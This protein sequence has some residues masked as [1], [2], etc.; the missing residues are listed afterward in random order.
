MVGPPDRH[1]LPVHRLAKQI[2]H[3]SAEELQKEL[4]GFREVSLDTPASPRTSK[5][6]IDI[7][8][9][10]RASALPYPGPMTAAR[11]REDLSGLPFRY[12]V[13]AVLFKTQAEALDALS[14]R[15]RQTIQKCIEPADPRPDPDKLY[16]ALLSG[17]EGVFRSR[18]WVSA[19]AVPCIQQ[20]L[21]AEREDIRRMSVELLRGIEAPSA[22]EALVRWAVFDVAPANRA[23]AVDALKSRDPRICMPLL[24]TYM[25]YPWPRA[26]EHAAEALVALQFQAA[27][28]ALAAML[29][30]PSPEFLEP[31]KQP[32]ERRQFRREIVRVNHA[33]NCLMCH[34]PSSR[35]ED[36]VRGAIPDPDK[37]LPPPTTPAY[38]QM[39]G[40]FV[41][42][43]TTYLRQDFSTVLP[44][45][46]PGK[47]SDQQ[48]F[49][50]LV[51][52]R[53]ARVG[54]I[55]D[56][57]KARQHQEALLFAL[58][59]LSGRDLGPTAEAW[60]ALR[61]GQASPDVSLT[62]EIA[63]FLSLYLDADPLLL[64]SLADF[65][66]SFFSLTEAEQGIV[67]AQL[68]RRFGARSTQRAL[69]AYLEGVIRTGDPTASE[70]AR[71][72]LARIL[73]SVARTETEELPI[74]A[75]MALKL[76]S[77][78][79]PLLRIAGASGLGSLG[80]NARPY[81]KEL[82]KLL[83][84]P[85]SDVRVAAAAALG[86]LTTGPDEMYEAL[87]RTTADDVALVRRT[88]AESLTQLKTVPLSA[89]KPLAE[90]LVKKGKWE[91]VEDRLAFE[92]AVAGLLA[93]MKQ[94]T[95]GFSAVL[96][97]AVGEIDSDVPAPTLARLLRA[98][99]PPSK[100]QLGSLVK[101]L[102]LPAYRT[103]VEDQLFAAGDDAIPVLLGALKDESEKMRMAA[104]EL[105]GRAASLARNPPVS[106]ASW[107]AANDALASTR[108]R[109]TSSEVQ[110][111]AASALKKLTAGK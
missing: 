93:D 77:N 47:W 20:M 91:K 33:R 38:Y 40:Q 98:L 72:V 14:R 69:I 49:D 86:Y 30:L 36:L 102:S 81:Y 71:V 78:P 85:E 25:R 64:L 108:A 92:K 99:G 46:N 90:G 94:P 89:A 79:S 66:S 10:N 75:A 101:L 31:A 50:F 6:L 45:A 95:Q 65:G 74:D 62:L 107:R 88:A 23:A 87:A 29:P 48:R 27:V 16:E 60:D 9:F 42:A 54:E 41:H 8:E 17:D 84:D 58:R 67:V 55:A 19:E 15:L 57:E 21:Q 26:A 104:A 44:V 82:I 73:P 100:D 37:P 22:T 80:K 61:S 34:P 51:V 53:P 7:A 3:R 39:G 2:D 103:V 4:L 96:K 56:Q 111:A 32:G 24:L 110:N 28:P 18:K 35:T 63:R 83:K 105:L 70:K 43:S 1:G 106:A 109:D 12:G 68:K 76:L 97:A 13:D 11:K 5:N 52:V 59:E